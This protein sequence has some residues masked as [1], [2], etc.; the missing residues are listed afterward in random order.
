MNPLGGGII[1]Q[2]P[3]LFEFLKGRPEQT[4]VEAAL[5]FL[6]DHQ[7]ISSTLVGFSSES[8]V[9]TA[10]HAMETYIPRSD[11]VLAAVKEK[12]SGSMEGLC[13]G[14]A[15]CDDCPQ[16]IPIPRY[17]DAYNQK[18]LTPAYGEKALSQRLS[19]H[20][21]IKPAAA[22]SCIACGQCEAACT[23]HLPIIE[24]LKEIAAL[25]PAT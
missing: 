24:R 4:V 13:T 1:P 11:A 16:G 20:W 3:E 7:D 25:K 19:L 21:G 6:W 10:L 12:S 5:H 22:A 8:D 18:L 9:E 14:C 23:Q 2:H 15:Y 17:M